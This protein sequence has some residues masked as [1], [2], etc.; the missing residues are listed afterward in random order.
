[1]TMRHVTTSLFG[2]SDSMTSPSIATSGAPVAR[3]ASLV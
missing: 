3:M 2:G 1:M